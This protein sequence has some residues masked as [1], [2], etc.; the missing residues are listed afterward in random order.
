MID[1]ITISVIKDIVLSGAAITTAYVAYA[2][3]EKWKAELTGKAN[4]EVAR[5]LIR[6]IYK[7]RDEIG[8]SRSAFIFAYEFPEG[9]QG[10]LANLSSEEKGQAWA[11]VYGNRWEPV[12]KALQ[13]FDS[14]TIEAEALWGA[15]IKEKAQVLRRLARE[16]QL[17]ME[18]VI[19][20]E[21]SNNEDF[22]DREFGQKIRANVSA[23]GSKN[24]ELSVK[25][26]DAIEELEKVIQPHLARS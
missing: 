12:G 25:I 5:T 6:S 18:A 13:D 14:E 15:E 11:H 1:C 22:E 3:V 17:S 20:N 26:S 19:Q 23:G 4:F 10:G 21:Y 8:Y 16:L 24:D 9:A 2:G 7:L